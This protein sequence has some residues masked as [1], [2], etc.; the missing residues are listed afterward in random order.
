MKTLFRSFGLALAIA[1][2]GSPAWAACPPDSIGIGGT[3]VDRYEASAWLVPGLTTD[4]GR[5]LVAKIQTGRAT[6]AELV[7]GGAQQLGCPSLGLTAYPASFPPDGDWTPTPGSP[8]T[9]PGV[10]AASVRGVPPST[11]TTWFQAE[12]ACALSGK[13]LLTNQEWQ[14]A[15]AGTPDPGAADD[16]ATTCATTGAALAATGTR[17]RCR[18]SWGVSDMVGNAWEWVADWADQNPTCSDWT[19]QTGVAGNDYACFGGDAA[20]A[21]GFANVPAAISRGGS[22]NSGV[23][24]GTLAIQNQ[25]PPAVAAVDGGFRCGR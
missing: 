6:V 22:V 23:G 25:D 7:A 1:A 20:G 11:C 21:F 12:Q 9:P 16:A 5:A 15:V 14:R 24:A 4:A 13:R 3:C 8:P 2:V 17:A 10:Y 19:T 18:S